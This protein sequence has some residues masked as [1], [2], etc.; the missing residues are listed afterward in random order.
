MMN[1]D[2]RLIATSSS[3]PRAVDRVGRL[4]ASVA[5]SRRLG[6][7]LASALLLA[8]IA[9]TARAVDLLDDLGE[10]G[11]VEDFTGETGFPTTPDV[12][13][14]GL[15]GLDALQLGDP[16]PSA[17]TFDGSGLSIPVVEAPGSAANLQSAG[18]RL[19]IGPAPSTGTIGLYGRFDGYSVTNDPV[20]G[21]FQTV[22][23][24]FRDLTVGNGVSAYLLSFGSGSLRIAISN[25]GPGILGGY[26][27]VFLSPTADAAIRG[28][29]AFEIE[30]RFDLDVR[31]L[32]GS[33][34]VGDELFVT[35]VSTHP[36]FD[37][38]DA[39]EDAIFVT[40]S[41]NNDAPAASVGARIDRIETYL[42]EPDALC[43]S[44]AAC[45]LLIHWAGLRRRRRTAADGP[46]R[47]SRRSGGCPGWNRPR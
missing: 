42:P 19:A 32:Q 27:Q 4:A 13:S 10:P 25:L 7:L 33:L 46:A 41:T 3:M 6:R 11:W 40:T 8:P 16:L 24:T 45:G 37:T 44:S 38:L 35:P 21:A 20:N 5:T 18:A 43:A 34:R 23:L 31:E 22:A 17:P 30:L 29:A 1:P 9:P 26:Q 39:L 15:G 47:R 28:G 2:P 36:S 12:D 14:N